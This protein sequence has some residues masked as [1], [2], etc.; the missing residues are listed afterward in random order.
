MTIP[1]ALRGV[2]VKWIKTIDSYDI[3][4]T[5]RTLREALT[6]RVPGLKV[7]IAS[8]ECML[9]GQAGEAEARKDLAAAGPW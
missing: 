6:T 8:G 9:S 2:G 3:G 7:I 4:T 5:I 1:Q